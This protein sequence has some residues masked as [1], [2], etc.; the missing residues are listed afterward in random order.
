[1]TGGPTRQQAK[2]GSQD[3][4][5]ESSTFEEIEILEA[6]HNNPNPSYFLSN[7]MKNSSL[8]VHVTV[9][10]HGQ[11][12]CYN[13]FVNGWLDLVAVAP[14]TKSSNF[15]LGNII[16]APGYDFGLRFH[17]NT[18]G[19]IYSA[20]VYNNCV[21]GAQK[22][23]H[24]TNT[25]TNSR[26]F[27]N[28]ILNAGVAGLEAPSSVVTRGCAFQGN[29]LPYQGGVVP[30]YTP[31][32]V[33]VISGVPGAENAT[34][35]ANDGGIFSGNPGSTD[36]VGMDL[37]LFDIRTAGAVTLN[38]LTFKAGIN[39]ESGIQSTI[40]TP[41]HVSYC[42]FDGL[43][44]YG[45]KLSDTATVK[46]CLLSVNGHAIKGN[47]FNNT[48]EYC[49]A[50]ACGGTFVLQ[51]GW[52][53]HLLHC[54]AQAC[55]YGLYEG[56]AASV[57]QGEDLILAASG[58]YDYSGNTILTYS[59]VGTLDP[60][61]PNALDEHSFRLDPLYRAP[62]QG[63]LRLMALAVGSKYDSP[64]KGTGSGGEDMGAWD[65]TYGSPSTAWTTLDFATVDANG[66]PYRNPDQ[67]LR[68]ELPIKLSEGDREDGGIYS[69]TAT[70]KLEYELQWEG[71]QNDMP[72]G[73]LAALLALFKCSSNRIQV[74]FGDGRGY[75][76]ACFAR[77]QGF[78]Y[79]DLTGLYSDDAMPRPL[80]S[81]VIREL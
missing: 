66:T 79:T 69:V 81:L 62:D 70:F 21:W 73:Q 4:R 76:E 47:R 17:E 56:F 49:L 11:A 58:A 75:V 10:T 31:A 43:G 36:D 52:S 63:D 77:Q 12:F 54:S 26:C 46:H 15:V 2:I 65:F 60:T 71:G 6:H 19:N 45:I 38:G 59:C 22:N 51:K 25:Q 74:D 30:T 50:V 32:A 64:A 20:W 16:S 18:T 24:F 8:Q 7:L 5:I 1:M 33:K 23:I 57:L 68:R 80:K 34:L 28:T 39:E 67:V 53:L 41:F 13:T 40:N 78:E 42:T 14:G 35:A 55:E 37:A 48:V 27:N 29:A 72:P 61:R 44:T 3:F 9:H